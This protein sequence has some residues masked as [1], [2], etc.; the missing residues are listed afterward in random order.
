[1]QAEGDDNAFIFL[2]WTKLNMKV[3]YRK[4]CINRIR[5]LATNKHKPAKL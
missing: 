3:P 4:N 5:N 2:N 1:M